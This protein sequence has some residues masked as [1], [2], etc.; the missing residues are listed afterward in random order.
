MKK[1]ILISLGKFLIFILICVFAISC[2]GQEG[3]LNKHLNMLHKRYPMIS[4]TGWKVLES[5]N[6]RNLIN[7][8]LSNE[9]M[10][11]LIYMEF[12][13]VIH[14]SIWNPGEEFYTITAYSK[15]FKE[16]QYE[17]VINGIPD[18]NY[19]IMYPISNRDSIIFISGKYYYQFRYNKINS[20]QENFY[21]DNHDS[22]NKLKGNALPELPGK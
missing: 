3:T 6:H 15:I 14:D 7:F 21:I 17:H 13:K 5:Y 2:S 16:G 9:I 1:F 8:S 12:S 10:D 20:K 22:L 11:T 19:H 4:K 18:T